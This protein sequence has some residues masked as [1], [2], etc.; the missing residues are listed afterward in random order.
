MNASEAI[1]NDTRWRV[2][3]DAMHFPS[4]LYLLDGLR[5]EGAEVVFHPVAR[6][7]GFDGNAEAWCTKP[8]RLRDAFV[9]RC[10]T[11]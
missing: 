2:V 1:S 5:A 11:G 3:T 8:L 6:P 4:L 9:R 10:G 7:P